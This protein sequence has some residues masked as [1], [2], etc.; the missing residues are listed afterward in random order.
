MA[1]R[2]TSQKQEF[3]GEAHVDGSFG[4][5]DAIRYFVQKEIKDL[6]LRWLYKVMWIYGILLATAFGAMVTAFF[7]LLAGGTP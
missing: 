4:S 7:K 6:E 5:G 3:S 1:P 2:R